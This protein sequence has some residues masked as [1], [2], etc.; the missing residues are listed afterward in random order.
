MVNDSAAGNNSISSAVYSLNGTVRPLTAVDGSFD[1]PVEQVKTTLP[2]A[3]LGVNEVCV[4]GTDSLNNTG[5]ATCQQFVVTHKFTGFSS[6]IDNT[7]VNGAVAGQ[8]VPARWRLAD[9]DD[10]P[11]SDPQ[12]VQQLFS[13]Q[14]NCADFSGDSLDSI[15]EYAAGSTGL[16]YL[17]DGRWQFNWKTPA[18][19]ANTCRAMYIAFA[20]GASS[21]V[22][23]FSFK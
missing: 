10:V 14:I 15:E 21:P 9:A 2:L 12:T 11:V 3:Q 8:T 22:V 13:Y 18:N 20:N 1:Q 7:L 5:P 16:V 19:Y 17:G 23:K 4:Q 6:P